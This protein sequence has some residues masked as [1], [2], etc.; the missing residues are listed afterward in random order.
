MVQSE[1]VVFPISSI[2]H[3]HLNH[4]WLADTELDA[5]DLRS[6]IPEFKDILTRETGLPFPEDPEE[7][8]KIAVNAVFD[9]WTNPRAHTSV[10]PG[11][12]HPSFA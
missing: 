10:I 1:V 9:S 12:E 2:P 11:L 3:Y 6:L 7:Q 5:H 4:L 8:L